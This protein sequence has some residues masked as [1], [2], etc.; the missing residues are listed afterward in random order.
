MMGWSIGKTKINRLKLTISWI[1]KVSSNESE[2]KFTRYFK[3][4]KDE[5]R[6]V[7]SSVPSVAA[8]NSVQFQF[9]ITF[10]SILS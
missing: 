4:F 8:S 10:M 7:D 5:H 2:G 3:Y 6:Q 1:I 9:K